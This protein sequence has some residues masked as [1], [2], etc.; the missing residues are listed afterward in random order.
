MN[1]LRFAIDISQTAA[2]YGTI[3]I[4]RDCQLTWYKVLKI[5]NKGDIELYTVPLEITGRS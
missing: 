2:T 5:P 4:Y 1:R 3:N